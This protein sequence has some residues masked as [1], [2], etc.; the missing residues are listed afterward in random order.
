MP[1]VPSSFVPQAD[2]QDRGEVPL[3]APGVEPVRNLAAD[4]QVQLGQAMT[5]AG[6][7]AWNVGSNI[8]DSIDEAGAKEAHSQAMNS[9][10][11]LLRGKNG[12]LNT[13]GKDAEV[14]FQATD[15]ALTQVANNV[16][17][18]LP[19]ET[20]KTLFRQAAS[21]DLFTYRGL[22][23]NHRNDQAKTYFLKE[24][25]ARIELLIPQAVNVANTR[26]DVDSNGNPS[27]PFNL[28]VET[29]LVEVDRIARQEG[30]PR[31]SF[32]YQTMKN[33][34]WGRVTSGV[35]DDLSLQH[36]FTA[37]EKYV[38]SQNEKG[39][40]DEKSR[41][42]LLKQVRSGRY[43][44]E[45]VEGAQNVVQTG[46]VQGISFGGNYKLPFDDAPLRN[47]TESEPTNYVS[48]EAK[49]IRLTKRDDYA[50]YA[51]PEPGSPL[52]SPG[53]GKVTSVENGEDG[54]DISIAMANG[55][56]VVEFKNFRG[57]FQPKVGQ[58]VSAGEVLANNGEGI[59]TWKMKENGKYFDPRAS[60]YA[61]RSIDPETVR[62]PSDEKEALQA[63]TD[64]VEDPTK[65]EDIKNKVRNDYGNIRH[66][67]SL[68]TQRAVGL[69]YSILA[70]DGATAA[71]IPPQLR[72]N[73]PPAFLKQI[74]QDFQENKDMET[75]EKLILDPGLL[76]RPVI[77]DNGNATSWI[78]TQQ[79]ISP[80]YRLELLK[81]LSSPNEKIEFEN[82]MLQSA[83]IANKNQK[84]AFPDMTV[85]SEKQA[86]MEFRVGFR[87]Y[88]DTQQKANGNVQLDR[89]QTRKAIDDYIMEQLPRRATVY[90]FF[91]ED[92]F[93][94]NMTQ[95]QWEKAFYTLGKTKVYL[96]DIPQA[97]RQ[98]MITLM[99]NRGMP[100]TVKDVAKAWNE[101][102]NQTK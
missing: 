76:T 39:L 53:D 32:Q 55:T 97:Q 70:K 8:Q 85:E 79:G 1:T 50:I 36:Q 91:N 63:V 81:Q 21:R 10:Q 30:I 77:D 75:K 6:N 92:M 5:R 15:D 25:S 47:H 43:S 65:R 11:E 26:N 2:T 31:D 3:Q 49:D 84:L 4:Q 19:N 61:D 28:A 40:L 42:S 93:V 64:Q 9:S 38:V 69:A 29:A 73:L 80:K 37:A 68:D 88:M 35:V 102:Q 33:N 101:Y 90:G 66:L 57:E 89:N 95:P 59:V 96:K 83:L 86:A 16:L 22:T 100:T 98:H 7:V 41:D 82:E 94:E 54:I 13:Q 71:N 27:G 18:S 20:Q 34:V 17:D 48:T 45:I 24:S 52:K 58:V 56:D 44:Q 51:N 62:P 87:D 23:N 14:S 60:N 12:Y 74:N 99:K 46:A 67:Q 72:K 78:E